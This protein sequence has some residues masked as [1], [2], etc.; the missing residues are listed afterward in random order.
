MNRTR[1]KICGITRVA[2]AHAAAAAGVD[3]IGLVFYSKSPRAVDVEQAQKI[4]R[5]LPPFVTVVAL[6][7]DADADYIHQVLNSVPVDLL[8]LHGELSEREC[9]AF[10]KPYIKPV[11]VRADTDLKAL[12]KQY[13]GAQ[14]LLLDAWHPKLAGG[15]GDLFDWKLVPTDL[16][17]PI[18]LAGGLNPDNVAQ[19]LKGVRPW[20][21]DVSGGV[22]A[23]KGIKSADKINAFMKAVIQQ[24]VLMGGK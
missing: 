10:G 6:F 16:D 9:A 15:T 18:I 13:P 21:V 22:E 8:Q 7:V 12:R 23:E 5:V 1:V 11:Q 19:A 14:A 24:D 2:D 4:V 17:F 20:A 3:A